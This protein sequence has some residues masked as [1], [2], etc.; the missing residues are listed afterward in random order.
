M[1]SSLHISISAEPI[2]H[3][4]SLAISNS[5]FTSLLVS[6]LILS[7]ALVVRLGLTA[8]ASRRPNGLQNFFE[9]M[10]E[11]FYGLA[12][13]VT[14]DHAKTRRFLPII[15]SFFVFIALNNLSGLIPGVGTIGFTEKEGGKTEASLLQQD[16]IVGD[17]AYA[18]EHV[19]VEPEAAA[20]GHTTE[21][22]AGEAAD[23]AVAETHEQTTKEAHSAGKFVPFF[24]PGTAD[25]N[26]TLALAIFTM[27]TVQ[28]FGVSYLGLG[29][30]KKF[31]N[32]SNPIM[33]FVGLLEIVSEFAKVVS[34]A[35]RLFGNIFAG[36]VLLTVVG[37][38]VPL[39]APMPFYGLE[40]FVAFVQA[41]VFS[42]LSL[43]FYNMATV[44]HDEH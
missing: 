4:G 11:G 41:L 17:V 7:L 21:E 12:H 9:W 36:E 38:L 32:F 28:V 26:T 37:S 18:S 13:G 3:L 42:L 8:P 35:F 14:N 23:P 20:V 10:I 15:M 30:F 29:Y 39:V 16:V 2:A 22:T 33:T 19:V 44:S 34:F 40:I 24:R 1:S 31:F 43:V 27:L 25:L 6:T 5:I